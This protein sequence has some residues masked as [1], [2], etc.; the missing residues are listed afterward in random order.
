MY[1]IKKN[2][3]RYKKIL[4]KQ[5]RVKEVVD[6]GNCSVCWQLDKTPESLRELGF[7][8]AYYYREL[9]EEPLTHYSVFLSRIF[10]TW[11]Y[12]GEK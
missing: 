9:C 7:N 12:G 6:V 4:E 2:G 5:G 3:M 8:C 1:R 10:Y 11:L